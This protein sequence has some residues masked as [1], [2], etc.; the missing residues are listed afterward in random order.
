MERKLLLCVSFGTTHGETCQ[1]NIGTVEDNLA[2]A[3]TDY[4]VRRAFTSG[5]VRKV[6]EKKGERVDDVPGALEQAGQEGFHQVVILPTHLLYGVEY[7]KLCRQ[8]QP[9]QAQFKKLAIAPPLL[10]QTDDLQEVARVLS[11]AFPAQP[12]QA[13]VFMGHGTTHYTNPVY[14]AMQTVFR[15]QG[16]RDIY[17]GTV[18]AWPEIHDI[19][20]QLDQGE[21]SKVLLAP[22]MLVAGD[23]AK[24]DMAAEE[25]SWRHQ[26][27]Q[28]GYQ[29]EVCLQGLGEYPAI[30]RLYQAH[31]A[32]AMD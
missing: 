20:A 12:G 7:E 23:H 32:K 5:M 18:E 4:E 31:A 15:L 11:A 2:R 26:L 24:N 16:R 29:V 6:L 28:A 1:K 8:A 25:N 3:F 13:V 10:A 17:V 27:T 14:A 22:F 30:C 9:Y 21:Y 19:Q